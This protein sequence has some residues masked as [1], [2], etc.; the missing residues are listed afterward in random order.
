MPNFTITTSI[1]TGRGDSLTATKSGQYEDVFNV[2]QECD[3]STTFIN[4][5]LGGSK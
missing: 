1:T 3:N 4:I 5:I 2:R